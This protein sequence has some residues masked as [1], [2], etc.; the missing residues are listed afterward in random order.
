[1]APVASVVR[2]FQIKNVTDFYGI[3]IPSLKN[4]HRFPT[5]LHLKIKIV[6]YAMCLGQKRQFIN[7]VLKYID[8]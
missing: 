7:V 5:L 8:I 6:G 1:M 3:S 2:H 4:S